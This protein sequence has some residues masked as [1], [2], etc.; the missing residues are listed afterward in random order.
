MLRGDL[1]TT[2]LPDVLRRLGDSAGTGCLRVGPGGGDDARVYL[3]DGLVYAVV[4]PDRSPRLGARLLTSGQLDP[5]ELAEATEAQRTEL[6]G[7]RLGELLVHLGYV[8]QSVVEA[9]VSE[10]LR[11]AAAELVLRPA[12]RWTFRAAER[13]REDIAPPVPVEDLLADIDQALTP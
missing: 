6:Q 5:A 12:E 10:Q 8:D 7:W 13:T 9:L 11:A 4:L 3:R 1:S 2:S